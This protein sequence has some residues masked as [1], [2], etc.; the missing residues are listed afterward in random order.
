MT[1]SLGTAR[2]P[3]PR[4]VW[5]MVVVLG[6]LALVPVRHRIDRE[7]NESAES[8]DT[9]FVSSGDTLR[10]LCLGY[11]GLMADIYWTRV[12]QYYGRRRLA[13]A[14]TFDLLGPLL[15]VTTTLDPHLLIAFRFG[16][17]F[18][19]AKPPGGAGQPERALELLR[20]GIVANPEYWRLWQDLG[21]IYYWDMQDYAG[22]ARA[23]KAGSERPHAQ[24][25]MKTL[26]A[27]VSAKGGDI[28]SSRFLWSEIYRQAE[29]DSIRKSAQEHL[30][31]LAAQEEM[32]RLDGLL[33]RY[34]ESEGY[35]ARSFSELVDAGLLTAVPLDPSGVAYVIMREGLAGR[36]DVGPASKVDLRLL[37]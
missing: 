25:W 27:M 23:F 19:A 30:A 28:H 2:K 9:L 18:L 4:A 17:I 20:R 31:A 33:V 36:V 7:R 6:V 5:R 35:A 14:M 32:Q 8:T 37:Q 13:K 21:F 15:R 22:A 26:A 29:N 34:Q 10:R 16:A 3:L 12:V 11:E 24:T 1:T